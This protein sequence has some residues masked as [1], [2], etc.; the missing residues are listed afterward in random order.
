MVDGLLLDMD[1]VLAQSFSPMPGSVETLAWIRDRGLPFRIVTN[2]TTHTRS[3][4]AETLRRGGL[5]LEAGDIVTAVTGTAAYLRAHHPGARVLLLT[6][7]DARGDLDDVTLAGSRDAADVVVLGGASDEFTY[8]AMNRIFRLVMDG[9]ALVGMHRNLYW[10]TMD[11]LELDG[12]AYLAGLEAATGVTAVICGKP[13]APFFE[14]ALGEL[15]LSAD[16]VA[17]VGDDIVNDVL[18][19]QAC[20]LIGVLVRTGKFMEADLAK[21]AADHVVNSIAELP[22]LLSR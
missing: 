7:G 22:E 18:G 5:D 8:A 16:R 21:G 17:M 10:R 9:A 3:D 6:D 2:T 1:G 12:G 20:G 19:A 11:G 13:S 4:L 15:G 14:S